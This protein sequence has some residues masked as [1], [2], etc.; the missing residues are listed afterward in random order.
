MKHD[1]GSISHDGH[2]GSQRLL[3][4]LAPE[5]SGIS[6]VIRCARRGLCARSLA[7]AALLA[8]LI[9]AVRAGDK[10]LNVSKVHGRIQYVKSFPDYKAKEVKSFPDLKVENHAEFPERGRQMADRRFLPRLQNPDGRVV[11]GLHRAI[12]KQLPRAVEIT[13]RRMSEAVAT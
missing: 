9:L 11:P 12:C 7:I 4:R 13:R 6:S 5:R 2:N 1:T 10:K 8:L 3:F